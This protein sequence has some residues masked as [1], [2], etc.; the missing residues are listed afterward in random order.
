MRGFLSL[1]V[2]LPLTGCFFGAQQAHSKSTVTRDTGVPGLERTTYDSVQTG[3][4]I[5]GQMPIV[6]SGG[7]YGGG[8]VYIQ[9]SGGGFLPMH[10]DE[11]VGVYQTTLVQPTTIVSGG[12]G[13]SRGTTSSGTSAD[14]S[15][16]TARIERLEAAVPKLAGG[17]ILSLQQS[18]HA[19]LKDPGMV[20]DAAEREK[21]VAGCKKLLKSNPATEEK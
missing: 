17:T 20:P 1:L 8:A 4:Y 14:V 15:D 16:L 7:G 11:R 12:S 19:I 13:G 3:S 5:G 10:N 21:I 18:C 9:G 6:M 2:C